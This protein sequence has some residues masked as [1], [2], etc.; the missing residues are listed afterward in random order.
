VKLQC[1]H[2]LLSADPK[3][4]ISATLLMDFVQVAGNSMY[5]QYGHQF[6]KLL[7]LLWREY[8]PKIEKVLLLG[9]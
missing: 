5:A 3:P 6:W 2:V 9:K 1:N 4:V 8:I 7:H